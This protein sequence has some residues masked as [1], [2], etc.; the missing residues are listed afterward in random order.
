MQ[1]VCQFGARQDPH[2]CNLGTESAKKAFISF[3][4]FLNMQGSAKE[5]GFYDA[6]YLFATNSPKRAGWWFAGVGS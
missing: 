6:V 1:V 2:S 5:K 3:L 4:R